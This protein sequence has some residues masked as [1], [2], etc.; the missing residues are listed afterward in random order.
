M[1]NKTKNRI[2]KVREASI[3]VLIQLPKTI[4]TNRTGTCWMIVGIC[5]EKLHKFIYS[6]V[7]RANFTINQS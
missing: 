3:R 7:C 5:L 1:G 2:I 4:P 6:K